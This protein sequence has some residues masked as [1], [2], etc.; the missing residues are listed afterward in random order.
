MTQPGQMSVVLVGSLFNRITMLKEKWRC[1]FRDQIDSRTLASLLTA[2]QRYRHDLARRRELPFAGAY[3]WI[4][5]PDGDWCLSVWPNAFYEDGEAGHVDVWRDLAFILAGLFPVEPNEVISAI[6]NCPY[7]LPRGRVV[8]MGDGRW[9][10]AHGNDHPVGLD[11][12]ASIADAFCLGDVNPIFFF[13]DHEQMLSC[14]RDI[15]RRALGI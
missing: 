12:E 7:G 4:P 6:E 1:S 11:L 5:A 2:H 8:K 14:D 15:V 13:D 10:V 3:Y 9:G